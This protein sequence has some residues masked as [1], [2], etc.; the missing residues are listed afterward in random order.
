MKIKLLLFVSLLAGNAVLISSCSTEKSAISKTGTE[1]PDAA[2]ISNN[3]PRKRIA[4]EKFIEANKMELLGDHQ[5]AINLYREALKIDPSNDAAYYNLAKI[6]YSSRQYA[7]AAAYAQQAIKL[8]PENTWYLD[9]YGTLLGGLGNYSAAEKV[10][11]RL[12]E[13]DP[14]NTDAWFNRAFFTEQNKQYDDALGIFNEIEERFGIS[15]DVTTEKV[16][17]WLQLGKK[18]K[19]AE[20]LLKL[21]NANAD[22]PK[23]YSLLVDFYITNKM[24]DKAYEVLQKLVALDPDDPRTNLVLAGYYQRK[25]DDAGAFRAFSK[26]FANPDLDV[27]IGIS[28]LLGYLPYFQNPL[29]E[30]E[31]KKQHALDLAQVL[32]SSHANEAK[33][34]AM[35]GDLL[36]QE[37][38][39]DEALKQ[40]KHAIGLD[41]SRFLVWQQLFFI[42][43]HK[44]NY[45]SLLN[46]SSKAIELFPDQSLTYYFSGYA[47]MQLKR[48]DDAIKTLSKA[49]DIG[50][51]DKKFLS[52]IYASMGDAYYYL[53]NSHA[54]DS[55][56]ELALVFDPSNAYVL[57]NYSYFLSLRGEK[58][59]EA[60]KMSAQSNILSPNNAAYE[61][62]YAWVLYKSGKFREAKQWL[63]KAL[64]HGGESDGSLLEHYGDI[65]FKLDDVDG[66]VK[67]WMLAKAKKV[68]SDTID[69]KIAER[70]LY[71]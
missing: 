50:M 67:Y 12:V 3:D 60:E 58:L 47:S 52:Q 71:E 63:E 54:S 20:E 66:A 16:K 48:Y 6:L 17:L 70:K 53:K 36:Y 27:D 46:V 30:N 1:F 18:D 9:L 14:E 35:Y 5:Q 32:A 49:I 56:Y 2:S 37:D 26:A 39:N 21:I 45:D 15:E 42:Y 34:Y 25:G 43:D 24:E 69:K 8:D 11:T 4:M 68:E 57:N 29:P 62:T 65:L 40:Y 38:K 7:E 23:Y 59:D 19:A 28:V 44:R 64:Q 13:V 41:S 61:D 51:G 22:E 55:C 31:Q 33:A 10:Y